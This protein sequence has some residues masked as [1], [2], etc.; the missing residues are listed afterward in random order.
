MISSSVT[1]EAI[2]GWA[3]AGGCRSLTGV[4]TC[5][6]GKGV[7]LESSPTYTVFV[8]FIG[9]IR[10]RASRYWTRE[11]LAQCALCGR[12]IKRS[13]RIRSAPK[14]DV[15]DCR[16]GWWLTG[17]AL[18]LTFKAFSRKTVHTRFIALLG[19]W[20]Y[21]NETAFCA[22]LG[23]TKSNVSS[24]QYKLKIVI[25]IFEDIE[26]VF[27]KSKKPFNLDGNKNWFVVAHLRENR[28]ECTHILRFSLLKGMYKKIP[29]HSV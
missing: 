20:V 15:D 7:I 9:L 18:E 29:V 22:R 2:S 12:R 6:V 19:T 27:S 21:R 5:N 3:V 16:S 14:V 17:F 25:L 23:P 1:S 28:S 13:G 8:S 11:R 24:L 4:R 10:I 26:R